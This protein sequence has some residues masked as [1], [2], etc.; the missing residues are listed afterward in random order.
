MRIPHDEDS[1]EH[2]RP[3][4][5]RH[6][7]SAVLCCSAC[8][9]DGLQCYTCVA[10]NADECFKQGSSVCPAHADA[11]STITGPNSLMKSCAYK[12]FCDKSHMSN[13]EM[14]LECCYNDDCNGPH[15]SHSHGNHHNGA[16][17]LSSG[18]LSG[19]VLIMGV[20]LLRQALN[21]F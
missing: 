10:T 8:Q 14:K 18:P 21:T 13:G 20:L 7:Q 17:R 6:T 2:A 19:P 4:H 16:A 15:H 3:F 12:S 9:G 11:C 1:P 5:C